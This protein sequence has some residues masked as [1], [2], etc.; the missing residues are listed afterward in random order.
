MLFVLLVVEGLGGGGEV[1]GALAG[2]W[3]W[4][5]GVILIGEL[6]AM[7]GVSVTGSCEL[8]SIPL[9]LKAKLDG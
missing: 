9:A 3:S 8:Q 1:A 5:A 4:G 2:A 6:V 7:E